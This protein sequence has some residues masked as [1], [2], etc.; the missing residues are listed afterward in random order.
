MSRKSTRTPSNAELDLKARQDED[1][2]LDS[3]VGRT[4]TLQPNAVGEDAFVGTDPIYQG[5]A[6]ETDQPFESESG[7]EKV[8]EDE[9]KEG[10][11]LDDV[12]EDKVHDDF[13][14]GGEALVAASP[15]AQPDVADV[16]VGGSADVTHKSDPAP[17]DKGDGD[18]EPPTPPAPPASSSTTPSTGN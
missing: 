11:S 9:F 7:P 3:N 15:F 2:E 13:G 14:M 5:R 17:E 4:V 16:V 1:H 12:D 10:F 8:A 6:N 18:N